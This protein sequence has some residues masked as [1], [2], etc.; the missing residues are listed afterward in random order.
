[1]SEN[2]KKWQKNKEEPKMDKPK[3]ENKKVEPV[4]AP[5]QQPKKRAGVFR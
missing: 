2:N 3:D 5:S 1:M 4:V